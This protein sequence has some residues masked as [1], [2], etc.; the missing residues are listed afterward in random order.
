[1]IKEYLLSYFEDEEI[2]NTILE[3]EVTED[4]YIFQMVDILS[5]EYNNIKNMFECDIK[6]LNDFICDSILERLSNISPS[7]IEN[8]FYTSGLDIISDSFAENTC[9]SYYGHYFIFKEDDDILKIIGDEF[10]TASDTII[11][12]SKLQKR[13][14][15]ELWKQ[16]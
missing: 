3:N 13:I 16:K 14:K 6:D 4:D 1:M 2:V 9:L 7:L 11:C 12:Y 5:E 15:E 10:K 8:R